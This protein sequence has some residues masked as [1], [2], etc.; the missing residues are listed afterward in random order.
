MPPHQGIVGRTL[1]LFT[2]REA[3]RLLTS[4]GFRIVKARPISTR[5]DGRLPWPGLFARLRAYGY[6][7]ASE[8]PRAGNRP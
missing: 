4:E 6:L 8:R 1:H 2:R 3:L 5:E 7:I